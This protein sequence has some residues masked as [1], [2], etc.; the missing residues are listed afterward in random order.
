MIVR[1]HT[2]F[3]NLVMLLCDGMNSPLEE[4]IVQQGHQL[5]LDESQG[6][7]VVAKGYEVYFSH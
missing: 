7:K 4:K 6:Y 1:R 3:P 2:H 5:I